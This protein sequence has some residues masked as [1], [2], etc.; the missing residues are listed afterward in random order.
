MKTF[1]MPITNVKQNVFI[2]ANIILLVL[3]PNQTSFQYAIV[4]DM[5]EL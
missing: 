3:Q 4:E 2:Q 5:N 1:H